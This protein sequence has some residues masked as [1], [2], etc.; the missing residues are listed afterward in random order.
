MDELLNEEFTIRFDEITQNEFER[1][2]EEVGEEILRKVNATGKAKVSGKLFVGH[3]PLAKQ[4][5][6]IW[7]IDEQFLPIIWEALTNDYGLAPTQNSGV[8][9]DLAIAENAK[10]GKQAWFALRDKYNGAKTPTFA[11]FSFALRDYLKP[12]GITISCKPCR[13]STEITEI[14]YNYKAIK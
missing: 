6:F 9:F 14:K 4:E 2:V 7:H 1:F 3:T 10:E 12:H 5:T 11:R 13:K 8:R